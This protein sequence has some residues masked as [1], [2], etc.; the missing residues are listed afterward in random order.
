MS[1]KKTIRDIMDAVDGAGHEFKKGFSGAFRKRGGK[2][3]ADADAI[4]GLDRRNA[5]YKPKHRGDGKGPTSHAK[6]YD[7]RDDVR[8]GIE[9]LGYEGRHRDPDYDAAR[10][11]GRSVGND[12][13][14]LPGDVLDEIK[15][16]PKDVPKQ[17]VEELY[18]DAIGQDNPDKYGAKS[19][20]DMRFLAPA[21]EAGDLSG[22][23]H[24][25]IEARFDLA[26]GSLEGAKVEIKTIPDSRF[27]SIEISVPGD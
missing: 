6:D 17:I 24:A 20:G 1:L 23:S 7:I 9:T 3:R 21:G 22:L 14:G 11:L 19:E 10:D 12:V 4:R 16:V 27:V 18:E 15:G 5:D 25:E 26:P 8:R 2:H 13:R